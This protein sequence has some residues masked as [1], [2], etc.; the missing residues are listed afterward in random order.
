MKNFN[1]FDWGESDESYYYFKSKSD[2]KNYMKNVEDVNYVLRLWRGKGYLDCEYGRFAKSVRI[3]GITQKR[4]QIPKKFINLERGEVN[5]EYAGD[6]AI[7]IDAIQ[8]CRT[9]IRPYEIIIG[10][11]SPRKV[12][13]HKKVDFKGFVYERALY[14]SMCVYNYFQIENRVL[15]SDRNFDTL[16]T[17]DLDEF[18]QLFQIVVR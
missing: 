3:N 17:L 9:S 4:Y 18:N 7:T 12:Y 15:I 13:L 11:C 2:L 5:L 14:G 6:P 8:L 10:S 16:G 1:L